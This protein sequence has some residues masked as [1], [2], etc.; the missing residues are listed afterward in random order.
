MAGQVMLRKVGKEGA[1]CLEAVL[2]I[3]MLGIVGALLAIQF[4]SRQPEYAI[5]IGV[6]IC[7]LIFGF[8]VGQFQVL[9]EK[10]ELLKA[11]LGGG[12][13]YLTVLVKVIGIAY[14]CEFSA[15]ICK[16]AGFG[17]V[18]QQIE[19][20]GKLAVIGAGL[21]ILFAVIEQIRGFS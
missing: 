17:A 3:G 6:G 20:L 13:G 8:V 1:V 9:F 12:E 21:P 18:A 10:F 4:R 19:I 15:A 16:D 5:L 2:K 11:Y 7:I 14:I